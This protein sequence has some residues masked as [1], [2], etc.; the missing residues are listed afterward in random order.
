MNRFQDSK[1]VKGLLAFELGG[2][3]EELLSIRLQWLENENIMVIRV[4]PLCQLKDKNY[5]M[6]IKQ[7]NIVILKLLS[8]YYQYSWYKFVV[9]A[10]WGTCLHQ[11]IKTGMKFPRQI[12]LSQITLFNCELFFVYSKKLPE[13]KMNSCQE[14]GESI[15]NENL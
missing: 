2:G 4:Y 5:R 15:G 11:C 9:N 1:G 6:K 10:P 13:K 14:V 7:A 8:S 12:L 3:W